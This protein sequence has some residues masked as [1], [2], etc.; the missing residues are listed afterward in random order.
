MELNVAAPYLLMHAFIPLLLSTSN[1]AKVL[2]QISSA[3]GN[4]TLVNM[5][6]GGYAL[7]KFAVTWLGE[8]AHEAYH[9][10]DGLQVFALQ[11]GGV[12]TDMTAELPERKGWEDRLIDVGLAGGV[13]VWLT[14]GDMGG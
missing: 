5:Q 7:S 14:M 2:I 1:G 13:C 6:A 12:K 4:W 10:R 9:K 3:W 11:P 8:L